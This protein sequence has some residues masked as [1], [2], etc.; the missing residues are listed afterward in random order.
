MTENFDINYQQKWD[1]NYRD[2]YLDK[3][4]VMKMGVWPS[5]NSVA[6]IDDVIVVKI[7]NVKEGAA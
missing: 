6:I 5:K 3:E 7:S 4:E 1:V 2:S